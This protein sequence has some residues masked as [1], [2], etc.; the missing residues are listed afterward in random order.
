MTVE[1]K[2]MDILKNTFSREK[3]IRIKKMTI[4]WIQDIVNGSN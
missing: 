2:I 4:F 3:V 1:K